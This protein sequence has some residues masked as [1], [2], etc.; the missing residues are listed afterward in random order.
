ME[1]AEISRGRPPRG[2]GPAFP[3]TSRSAWC[4]RLGAK[5]A[6]LRGDSVRNVPVPADGNQENLIALNPRP[7]PTSRHW[8]RAG[9]LGGSF[10]AHLPPAGAPWGNVRRAFGRLPDT[11]GAL[12]P[13][14]CRVSGRPRTI[15]GMPREAFPRASPADRV[16]LGTSGGRLWRPPGVLW[17]SVLRFSRPWASREE[18]LR[19]ARAR[20]R[21]RRRSACRLP[22]CPWEARRRPHS[23]SPSPCLRTS[24]SPP[25]G[26]GSLSA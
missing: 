9:R 10:F 5:N 19:R 6:M 26:S 7:N 4:G 16:R 8:P 1:R 17:R 12:R 14:H 22:R 11:S 23:L 25:T 21:R 24:T 20:E 13:R 18:W 15:A 2:A 3:G